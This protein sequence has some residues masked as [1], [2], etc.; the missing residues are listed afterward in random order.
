MWGD[1]TK[2]ALIAPICTLPIVFE[3]TKSLKGVNI[4]SQRLGTPMVTEMTK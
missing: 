2:S 3:S 4:T 1:V